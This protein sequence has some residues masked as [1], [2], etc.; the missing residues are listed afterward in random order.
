M[1]RQA[2]LFD[3]DGVLVDSEGVYYEFW[4]NIDR[5]FPTGIPDFAA[6]IKK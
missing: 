5:M 4:D 6:S 2:A 3:L 1:A